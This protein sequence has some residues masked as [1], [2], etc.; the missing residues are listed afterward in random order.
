MVDVALTGC[1]MVLCSVVVVVECVLGFSCTV[2]QAD[3]AIKTAAARPVNI[4]FFMDLFVCG[5]GC[6]CFCLLNYW[7]Y[8]D[9]GCDLS[10]DYLGYNHLIA[11]FDV[12]NGDR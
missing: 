7:S 4:R 9:C 3:N 6:C 5:G 10:H 8:W 11:V 1:R 12:I 2:V